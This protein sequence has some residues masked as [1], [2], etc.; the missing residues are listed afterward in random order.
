[1][2]LGRALV[3]TAVVGAVV[4]G[5]ASAEITVGVSMPL[6]GPA[7]SLGIPSKAGLDLWPDTIGGEKVKVS[8]RARYRGNPPA[9]DR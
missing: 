3:L 1:M 9:T 4:A 8:G 5:S 7:A 2:K 6:T